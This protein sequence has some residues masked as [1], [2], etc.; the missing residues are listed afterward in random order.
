MM[1]DVTVLCTVRHGYATS[2]VCVESLYAN[3]DVPIRVVFADIAS[4][5][6]ARAYLEEQARTRPGF[7]YLRL[8]GLVSR[9]TARVAALA[10]VETPYVV[11][12]DNN[13]ICAPGWLE[14]LL[15]ARDETGASVVSP[16]IVTHGGRV[17]FSAGTVQRKRRLGLGPRR[18]LRPHGQ[19]EAPVL[20]FLAA[21]RP[22]RLDIDFAESHCCLAVTDDLRMPGVLEPGMHNA[23]TT[24]YASYKLKHDFGKRLVLEPKAV[25][26]IV[27]IGFGYDLPWICG[28]Y[29][30]RD[31]LV[32]S[33]DLLERLIGIGPG[34]DLDAGLGWH[35]KHLKYLLLTMLE[36]ERFAREDLLSVSEV[37]ACLDGYDLPLPADADVRLQRELMPRVA[38]RSPELLAP[39]RYWLDPDR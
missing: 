33:Y 30:R 10:R 3:T 13:M 32:S 39:L 35:V 20:S 24:C 8:P 16:I 26:S 37:P 18:V 34:T 31:W 29:M 28:S 36:G 7:T 4:P 21:G 15:K 27:P 25:A 38:Q 12:L 5:D 22:Q 23:H 9:Q 6:A 1:P 11:L 14:T 17:H 19:A 2:A